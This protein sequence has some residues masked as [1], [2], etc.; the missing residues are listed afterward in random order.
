VPAE[1]GA[2]LLPSGT[3]SVIA[4]DDGKPLHDRTV[5]FSNVAGSILATTKTG[6]DGSASG[7]MVPGGMIT[8]A[9]GTSV[10]HLV[11]V[12][13]VVPGDRILIGEEEDEGGVG[14]V[15]CRLAITVPGAH[16]KAARL[17]VTAGV[18]D[19]EVGD[20]SKPVTVAVMKRFVVDGKVRALARA[21]DA[22]GGVVAFS[23]AF[24]EG[25]ATADAGTIATRLPA[26]STDL[27]TF[28]IQPKGGEQ[29][30]IEGALVLVPTGSDGVSLGRHESLL[31][32]DT[33]LEFSAPRPLGT[34]AHLK[35]TVKFEDGRDR[36][37]LEERYT[38]LAE[39]T[40]LDLG[41]RLLPR[42]RDAIVDG[43]GGP[44]PN[45]RWTA[46]GPLASA[47]AIVV[48]FAWPITAEHVWTVLAPPDVPPRIVVPE[49]PEE[50]A[51]WRPD[52]RSIVPSVG[53]IDASFWGGYADVKKKGLASI[54]DP[55]EGDVVIRSSM[56][57]SLEF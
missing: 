15:M 6:K 42:I 27:R 50:L 29:G 53:A 43:Q 26:W 1:A 47:D 3:A 24:A 56:T 37:S 5:V 22:K 39:H 55:P 12:T 23:Q 13:S 17:V 4:F 33:K 45:I 36:A 54:E 2:T 44:R 8:V 41:A 20:P 49:L 19:A 25:C 34:R 16:P 11:T 40:T 35:L 46:T 18:N 57:G 32:A 9:H 51:T 21:L 14:Q 48:R 7:P 28:V 38:D 31:G 30:T 10:N 52:S